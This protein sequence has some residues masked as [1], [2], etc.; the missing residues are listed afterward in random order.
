M[1]SRRARFSIVIT[2]MTVLLLAVALT[3]IFVQDHRRYVSS[4]SS[5][6]ENAVNLVDQH[7]RSNS[8]AVR[9]FLTQTAQE[10]ERFGLEALTSNR[11]DWERF[12]NLTDKLPVVRSL[13]FI[14]ANGQMRLYTDRYPTP[15]VDLTQRDYVEIHRTRGTSELFIGGMLPGRFT[16]LPFFPISFPA[17]D[18]DGN[19]QAVVAAAFEPSFF[20]EFIDSLAVCEPC[21]LALVNDSGD[22][23][24]GALGDQEPNFVVTLTGDL[25]NIRVLG[26]APHDQIT[27]SWWSGRSMAIIGSL[28][29]LILVSILSL[30]ITVSVSR[31][32]RS[33]RQL[34][35]LNSNLSVS[36]NHFKRAQQ[37]ARLCHW[38]WQIGS[39][40]IEWSPGV[41]ETFGV[42]ASAFAARG[43]VVTNTFA[44]MID[45]IHRDEQDQMRAI[46]TQVATSKRS[47]TRVFRFY[48][49]G[50][51][52]RFVSM[53]AQPGVTDPQSGQVLELFGI[54][55]D[56]TDKHEAQLALREAKDMADAANTAKTMFL[57]TISHDIRTPL[58]IISNMNDMILTSTQD[59][60]IRNYAEAIDRASENLLALVND[61]ISV[62]QLES[63]SLK[64]HRSAV[65]ITSF[66]DRLVESF[67]P[68]ASQKGISLV[69]NVDAGMP[70]QVMLDP[71]VLRQVM[72][73]LVGNALKFT[74]Y[75][76]VTVTAQAVMAEN[77]GD[78][79]FIRIV[80]RDTGK[81]IPGD[82]ID[83]I[84]DRFM[85]VDAHAPESNGSGLG[86]YIC[87]SLVELHG[88]MISCRSSVGIGSVFTVQLPLE[89]VYKPIA[90]PKEV[91]PASIPPQR[92]LVADD[93]EENRE[94]LTLI[95]NRKGH[96]VIPA[97]NGEEALN[98]VK[99]RDDLDIV[100]LDIRMPVMDGLQALEAIRALDDEAK[101]QLPVVAITA[102]ALEE[103]RQEYQQA[104]FD[105]IIPKP[106]KTDGV[107]NTIASLIDAAKTDRNTGVSSSAEA[108]FDRDVLEQVFEIMG[109]EKVQEHIKTLE[110]R[111]GQL[112]ALL[113]SEGLTEKVGDQAHSIAGVAANFG[114]QSL[115]TLCLEI[116]RG[117]GT[118]THLLDRLV[119]EKAMFK[120]VA[121]SFLT[122]N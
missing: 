27:A 46:L 54:V 103:Q 8:E 87:R 11:T 101:V 19:V 104:G 43:D 119:S 34:A 108:G 13:W 90:K 86:L 116:E 61:V 98:I 96:E 83:T 84:F 5:D 102:N 44:S 76:S 1:D 48:P 70:Q 57:A 17:F 82:R 26:F 7:V 62:S 117:E 69:C 39:D 80:V 115:S 20:R 15:S 73:N 72:F 121:D 41:A 63:G 77:G 21:N 111:I 9:L 42:E 37:T 107:L 36:R 18:T 40:E 25:R 59:S 106:F 92:I 94:I 51:E 81:G 53:E 35:D 85:Q 45:R 14:D 64:L 110:V 49:P 67:R 33:A 105:A 118:E 91:A 16:G 3:T 52:M 47:E 71:K 12:R 93:V 65:E 120:T 99:E 31:A 112:E 100:L 122:V 32:A 29:A 60:S 95:L 88:G 38:R 68:I 109:Q 4:I 78:N 55:Q 22:V 75:G 24:A 58:N 74:K 97:V 30:A 2:A 23:F 79:G 114:F 66:L 56:V 10:I 89:I 113:I 6:V 50:G 28:V